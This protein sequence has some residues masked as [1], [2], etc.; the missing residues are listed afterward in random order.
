MIGRRDCQSSL[1]MAMTRSVIGSSIHFSSTPSIQCPQ[2]RGSGEVLTS[3]SE[4]KDLS[5]SLG[6][7]FAV[8]DGRSA[9]SLSE[10][11]ERIVEN[12]NV[13]LDRLEHGPFLSSP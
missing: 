13:D 1:S 10:G 5:D 8:E 6:K 9:P 7:R 3:I 2:A 11:L 4:R 12:D